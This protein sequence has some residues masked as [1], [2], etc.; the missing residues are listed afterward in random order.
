MVVIACLLDLHL[1]V[2]SVLITTDVM[3]W[4]HTHDEVESTQHYVIM[5]V[6]DLRQVGA[7]L[8][9]FWFPLPIILTAVI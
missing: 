4:N 5:F 8:C 3:S 2:Y 9:K 7:F 1:S 6:S